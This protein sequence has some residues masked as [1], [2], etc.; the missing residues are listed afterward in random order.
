MKHLGKGSFRTLNDLESRVDVRYKPHSS[1][2]N[3]A[4]QAEAAKRPTA[5]FSPA[6]ALTP[7]PR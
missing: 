7:T 1:F 6:S 2:L 3:R 4:T 5:V